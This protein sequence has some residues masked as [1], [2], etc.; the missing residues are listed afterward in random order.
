MNDPF[1]MPGEHGTSALASL[2]FPQDGDCDM[3]ANRDD[4]RPCQSL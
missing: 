3:W 2:P 1:G 4:A